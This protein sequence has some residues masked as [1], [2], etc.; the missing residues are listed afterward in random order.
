MNNLKLILDRI[1][2]QINITDNIVD[3]SSQFKGEDENGTE[4]EKYIENH[5]ISGG[6]TLIPKNINM[7]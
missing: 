2:K 1:R 4:W 5:L 3:G 7:I 6:F